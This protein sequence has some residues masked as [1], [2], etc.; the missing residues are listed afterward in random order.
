M[1]FTTWNASCLNVE[2]MIWTKT[3]GD[4]WWNET[5]SKAFSN[6]DW[7]DNFRMSHQT[8]VY[9]CN[10]VREKI[11]KQNTSMQKHAV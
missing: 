9:I 2:R 11:Q 6:S 3:R 7:L 10:E 4:F 1:T 8:F 5:V